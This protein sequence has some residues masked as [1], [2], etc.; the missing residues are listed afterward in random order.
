ME[1][2]KN[3]QQKNPFQAQPQRTEQRNPAYPSS[4]P[5]QTQQKNPLPKKPSTNW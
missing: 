5:A 4:N 1:K 3:A 2:I